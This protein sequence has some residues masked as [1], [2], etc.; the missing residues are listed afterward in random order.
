MAAQQ[1]LF[2]M[3]MEAGLKAPVLGQLGGALPCTALTP[4][5]ALQV[6][7][8]PG[9][10]SGVL[11]CCRGCLAMHRAGERSL[12]AESTATSPPSLRCLKYTEASWSALNSSVFAFFP[13]IEKSFL[14]FLTVTVISIELV[15]VSQPGFKTSGRDCGLAAALQVA[16][17]SCR[18]LPYSCWELHVASSHSS[19]PSSVSHP[20]DS[21]GLGA[22]SLPCSSCPWVLLP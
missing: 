22:L 3:Q 5:M 18:P 9:H 17:C 7:P 10:S 19:S 11:C 4:Q 2:C 14:A 1:L 6:G 12:P 13:I 16:Q 8:C 20:V 21:S 15:L